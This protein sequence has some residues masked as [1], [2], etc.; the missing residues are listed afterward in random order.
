MKD[1][2][3]EN[4][5]KY[6]ALLSFILGNIFLFG[7]IFTENIGFALFGYLY[8]FVGAALNLLI[9]GILL[10]YGF[11]KPQQLNLCRK[12]ALTLLFNIPVA[13]LYAYIGLR[14]VNLN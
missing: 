6:A 7:Y 14:L 2:T 4:L 11:F 13:I 9:L 3:I 12:S 8:L 1:S 5:G 10:L